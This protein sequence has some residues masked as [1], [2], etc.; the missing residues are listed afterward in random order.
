[1]NAELRA[2]TLLVRPFRAADID[3]VYEAVRESIEEVS[4]WLPWCHPDYAKEETSA[5]ILSRDEA[6]RSEDELSFGVFDSETG[7][8]LGGVGLNQINR[9]YQMGNLGYWVRTSCAGRGVAST[10]ARRVA[11]FGFDMLGLQR[12]EI[13][14]AAGNRAS[15]RVAEKTGALLEGTLRKRLLV[16]GHPQDAVL[17]SLVAEDMKA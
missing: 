10:A 15:Q 3:A 14:A 6:W 2:G 13:I 16:N 17:Y 12:I 1:M 7:G 9:R 8:F 11:R 4:P 5:F